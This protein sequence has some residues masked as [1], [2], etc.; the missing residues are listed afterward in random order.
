MTGK[1]TSVVSIKAADPFKTLFPI[2]PSILQAIA[3]DIKKNGFDG[4]QPIHVW[5]EKGVVLDGH[6]RLQAAREAGLFQLPVFE[7]SFKDE[8]EAVAYAIHM[9]R[10]RRNLTDAELYACVVELDKR[11]SHGG[12]RVKVDLPR[13][14]GHRVKQYL[15]GVRKGNGR[16][17]EEIF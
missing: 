14:R 15:E 6:T 17:Q 2:R 9:Q 1:M 16:H 12:K 5:K 7:H 4:S 10:D 8:S 3:E 13:T 11:F